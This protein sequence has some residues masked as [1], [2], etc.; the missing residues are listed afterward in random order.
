MG[1][2]ALDHPA[3]LRWS[4]QKTRR[5]RTSFPKVSVIIPAKNEA[6]N[7]P[8]VF[9]ALPDIVSE[10]VLVDGRSTDD[11]IAVA[12]RLRPDVIV[13]PQSYRGKGDALAC[14]FATASGD[15]IVM[16]DADGSTDA[17]RDP[18]RSSARW[19]T[20]PTSPRARRFLPG[21]GSDDLTFIRRSGNA[22]LTGLVNLAV[23]RALHRPLLRLQRLLARLPHLRSTSTRPASRSRPCSTSER[24]QGRPGHPGGAERERNRI[25]GESNLHAVRDGLRVLRTILRERLSPLHAPGPAWAALTGQLQYEEADEVVTINGDVAMPHLLD[26]AIDA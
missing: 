21:G 11:T 22:G 23:R 15:I 13:V 5:P 24:G 14:G 7:L 6:E 12:R 3:A 18:R 4:A 16:I 2:T 17:A 26:R 10:V 19:S 1:T 25:H 9:P 8:H 20:A